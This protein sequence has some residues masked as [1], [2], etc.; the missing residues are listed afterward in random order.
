MAGAAE[1]EE[2][3]TGFTR[4][5]TQRFQ[6][7]FAD[8]EGRLVAPGAGGDGVVRHGEHL[9]RLGHAMAGIEHLADGPAAREIM[10]QH[11][12]EIE[13]RPA[14][15][16]I[17]HHAAVPD[18]VEHGFRHGVQPSNELSTPAA[19]PGF[20]LIT[21][22]VNMACSSRSQGSAGNSGLRAQIFSGR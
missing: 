7:F 11:P 13:Q 8:G 3:D 9:I 16:E 17:S 15:A 4:G 18:L 22:A 19:Q 2:P 5:F 20:R 6:Q 21:P 14:I 1:I 10:D 12:V